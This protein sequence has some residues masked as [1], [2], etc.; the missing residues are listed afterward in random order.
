MR[1]SGAKASAVALGISAT[2]ASENPVGRAAP[3]G[4]V[5]SRDAAYIIEAARIQ[6]RIRCGIALLPVIISRD[7]SPLLSSAAGLVI[8]AAVV[9]RGTAFGF[10][11]GVRWSARH[12]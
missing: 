3:A 12:R 11:L 2:R 5:E 10:A 9:V 4:R 8:T 7:G 1:P 6:I